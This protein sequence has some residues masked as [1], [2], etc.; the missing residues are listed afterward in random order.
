MVGQLVCANHAAILVHPLNRCL[1]DSLSI[2]HLIV[3]QDLEQVIDHFTA[4]E[5]SHLLNTHDV[6]S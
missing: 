4:A 3:L 5:L 6:V 1:D 2:A